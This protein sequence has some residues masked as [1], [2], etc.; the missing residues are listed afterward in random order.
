[1][2]KPEDI[3]DFWFGTLDEEGMPS[4]EK[5]AIWFAATKATDQLIRRRFHSFVMLASEK[6][7]P[8]WE[9]TAQGRLALI[10][11]LDQF[12][13]NIY[14]GL[15]LAFSND[16]QALEL[17]L[18]GVRKGVDLQLP[19][20]QRAFFYMPLQHSEQR[21]VQKRSVELFEQLYATGQGPVKELLKGFIDYAREHRQIIE[22][23]G[24]FPHR[25]A[26]LK[27]PSTEAEQI[28]L[29]GGAPRYGQ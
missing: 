8:N 23:F 16:R 27:R 13:R 1:M 18:E 7:L 28:Y 12:S 2:L 9:E 22:R 24:R 29:E 17:A 5:K 25:N 10:L 4:P 15:A 21:E 14:R 6:G 3:L 20:V 26:V 19:L 11:L